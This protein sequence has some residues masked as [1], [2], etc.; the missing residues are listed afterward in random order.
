MAPSPGE[1]KGNVCARVVRGG[2]RPRQLGRR[3]QRCNSLRRD[4]LPT[5]RG[6]TSEELSALVSD[7]EMITEPLALYQVSY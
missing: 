4:E 1:A 3:G 5:P 2:R 6:Y 7:W